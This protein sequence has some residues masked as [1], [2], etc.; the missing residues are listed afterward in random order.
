M[1]SSIVG[2]MRFD[3]HVD[4]QRP[5]IHSPWAVQ[6]TCTGRGPG[7]LRTIVTNVLPTYLPR[8]KNS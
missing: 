8:G 3:R 2:W 1:L 4:T 6:Q 7:L 5:R